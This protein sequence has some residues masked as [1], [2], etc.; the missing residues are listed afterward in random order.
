MA[1]PRTLK[2]LFD[3]AN[4]KYPNQAEHQRRYRTRIFN[5]LSEEQQRLILLEDYLNPNN[6]KYEAYANAGFTPEQYEF[7]VKNSPDVLD[8]FVRSYGL[9]N[10]GSL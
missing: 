6:P 7:Y 8:E 4:A 5:N 2:E 10:W 9:D 1:A 3:L